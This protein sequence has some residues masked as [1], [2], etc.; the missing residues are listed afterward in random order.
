MSMC[1]RCG[2]YLNDPH[3]ECSDEDTQTSEAAAYQDCLERQLSNLHSLLRS[4]TLRL[5]KATEY[6]RDDM[7]PS[8]AAQIDAVL[9]MLS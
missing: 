3:K 7:A 2:V 1:A 6:A 8:A 5:E 4:V 9:E